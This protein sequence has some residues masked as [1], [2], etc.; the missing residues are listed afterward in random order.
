MIKVNVIKKNFTRMRLARPKYPK[1]YNINKLNIN[2]FNLYFI[3]MML[4]FSN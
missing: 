4:K 2:S 1:F 3:L